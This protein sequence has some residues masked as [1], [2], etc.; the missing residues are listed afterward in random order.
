MKPTTI[1]HTEYIAD[2][3]LERN[4]LLIYTVDTVNN[5]C[6]MADNS[7]SG[8]TIFE[9]ITLQSALMADNI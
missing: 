9:K 2:C 8:L 7:S 5:R 3:A 6:S 1:V 4:C